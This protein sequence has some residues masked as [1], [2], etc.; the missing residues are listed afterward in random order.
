[1]KRFLSF[2]HP[3]LANEKVPFIFNILACMANQTVP[4]ILSASLSHRQHEASP[5]HKIMKGNMGRFVV[6]LGPPR[7]LVPP[8]FPPPSPGIINLQYNEVGEAIAL[9]ADNQNWLLLQM[10]S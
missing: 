9:P 2:K 7:F 3:G 5:H 10:N 1:M 8:S 4:F 6:F